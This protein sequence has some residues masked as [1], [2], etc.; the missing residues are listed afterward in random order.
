M[1][2]SNDNKS[3]KISKKTFS[4]IHDFDEILKIADSKRFTMFFDLYETLEKDSET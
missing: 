4:T 1:K 2:I 3:M